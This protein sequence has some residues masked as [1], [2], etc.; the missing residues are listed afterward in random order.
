MGCVER[1]R[2]EIVVIVV[3]PI[4]LIIKWWRWIQRCLRYP[5]PAQHDLRVKAVAEAVQQR[6]P[7]DKLLRTDRSEHDSHSV[8]N[9][10]K[11]ASQ[12]VQLRSLYAILG[13]GEGIVHVEPGATV[14]EVTAYLLKLGL[15]LECTLE[16]AD[17]TL[18]G[19]AMATGMTTHSHVC[20]LIHETVTEYEVVTAKGTIVMARP[21]NEHADLWRALPFSHGTLG[22][23]V[24]L[25]LRVLPSKAFVRLEYVPCRSREQLKAEYL[26]IL[27]AAE[28]GDEAS[29]PFFVES[30][31]FS[32]EEAVL[33][34]GYLSAGGAEGDGEVRFNNVGWWWK[35]WFYKHVESMLLTEGR[36]QELIPIWDYLMRHDRSMCMTMGTVIPYGNAPWFRFLLGWLLPPHMSFL[37]SSHTKETREASIRAQVY[38]DVA[39]PAARV[40]EA[41]DVVHELFEVYPLMM[42]PCRSVGRGGMLKVSGGS[43]GEAKT[44]M[45]L[46]LGI[47][48]IPAA[49]KADPTCN[50]PMLTNVRQLE[51][52]IR[53]AGGF[54]H[55]YCDSFQTEEEFRAMFDHTLWDEMRVRYGGDGV[56]PTVYAKTRPE[57]DIWAYLQEEQDWKQPATA[58]AGGASKKP[59]ATELPLLASGP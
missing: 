25:K 16:M 14:G 5:T 17:A 42:Y 24:S 4:S 57:Q 39:F 12:S 49:K 30:L 45:M 35:P 21:D 43:A 13:C 59:V 2:A 55:T 58:A 50:F 38:Q 44:E 20:G 52:W 31:V 41:L 7:G 6:R 15:Q 18:G 19:L 54:Q 36:T 28:R 29:T 47:Y 26:Q 10:D 9:S 1:W 22:M 32:R 40:D 51:G 34:K 53:S 8:R 56:F 33:M 48:G 37:K 11:S 23:L 3:L 46:N 27:E